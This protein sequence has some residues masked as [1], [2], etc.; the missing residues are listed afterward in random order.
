M[1]VVY[2]AH[3]VDYVG[4]REGVRGGYFG[5]AGGAAVQSATFAE[6]GWAGSGVDD[7]VLE[8]KGIVSCFSLSLAKAV[9]GESKEGKAWGCG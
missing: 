2:G 6:E 8:G 3:G 7:A 1:S 5:G 9:R 4:G